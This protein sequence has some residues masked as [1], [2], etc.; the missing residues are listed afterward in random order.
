MVNKKAARFFRKPFLF[1]LKYL[2]HY[3][4]FLSPILLLLLGF[5]KNA[6]Q[7]INTTSG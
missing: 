4:T 1:L 5:F 6:V 2:Q 3:F 7:N